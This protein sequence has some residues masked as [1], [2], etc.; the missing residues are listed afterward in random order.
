M[1][2]HT[3][4]TG[5]QILF[6]CSF[7]LIFFGL[8]IF[9]FT[10]DRDEK[11]F[12]SVSA[13]LFR[14]EMSGNTLTMHYT[15]AYPENFG[16]YGYEA[17]LPC[18]SAADRLTGQAETENLLALLRSLKSEKLSE[19][20]RYT[21]KLLI[22]SL[23]NSLAM[24]GYPYYE[25][26]LSPSSGMQ[27]Q[28]PIL[29]A[30]YTFRT[31]QDVEDYLKLLDQTDRYFASLLRFE[32]EKAEAG[33]L[34]SS[35]SLEKVR[36]QCDTILTEEALSSG[37]HFLQTTFRERLQ[38]LY[39]K[40]EIGREEA[41]GYL[42]QNNR[43]LST[44]MLPAYE[45]L[46]D[47]L[48]VLKDDSIPLSGLAA[49]P[50]GSAYYQR[51]LYSETG[52]SR[53][54]EELRALLTERFSQDYQALQKL[55]QDYPSAAALLT[56]G[57]PDY[58]I[59]CQNAVQVLTDLQQ[60][61][62]A[63]FPPLDGNGQ[64]LP[65]V[66]V[67]AISPS[68]QDYCAPAFYLTPPLD[69]TSENVI[70]INEKSPTTGLELYTT[71]AHEGY[72]GH[73]YQS[74]Y[75]N[76][77]MTGRG[78]NEVRQLLWYG[79]YLE[80]WALYV[81]FGSF[82]YASRMMNEQGRPELAAC[83]QLEKHNRSLQLCL[84]SLLDIMIHY[85]GASFEQAAKVM[86]A[87]GIKNES[88]ARA[89]YRY[90]AEEPCNYPKYYIG[91]LEILSLKEEAQKLW[92]GQYTDY[93]FHTFF[94]DCGPSDFI[95]LRERLEEQPA[96]VEQNALALPGQSAS[97]PGAAALRLISA[98]AVGLPERRMVFFPAAVCH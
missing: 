11:R 90:I 5:R 23:D 4:I 58:P 72:P 10:Y 53:T 95:S 92:G 34:M 36:E 67:K 91:Y 3:H 73:L 28:L 59:P 9:L 18:Y 19:A 86:S 13:Q 75:S 29:L 83:I 38:E 98:P 51:L 46:S 71:L 26:P 41:E 22:R 55:S 40:G 93:A 69:D 8:T 79:G 16:I 84:Y 96:P 87:F 85:D 7:L 62:K 74:V 82:D 66:A 42:N 32:Q 27:S 81:E 54:V 60:R 70:Y 31:K 43:L 14:E 1:K 77:A 57:E 24:S 52:S 30:E 17:L 89:V 6:A 80:G 33:L 61:M 35:A 39:Q 94:L 48:L 64:S 56:A 45:A 65:N 37:S 68:L 49:K 44:V 12:D 2:I 15:L 88:S 47:G 20:D 25:E 97:L 21:L 76:R 78:E 63:D 50:D